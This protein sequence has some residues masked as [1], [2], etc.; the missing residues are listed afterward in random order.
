MRAPEYIPCV[1]FPP[2]DWYYLPWCAVYLLIAGGLFLVLI[3][4]LDNKR[5]EKSYR[6]NL[7]LLRA[8][9][10]TVLTGLLAWGFWFLA[11][12][13]LYVLQTLKIG[14]H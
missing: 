13:T 2:R 10:A 1:Q 11:A 3:P 7:Y 6:T 8:A 5:L 14:G 4:L 9:Y 12:V